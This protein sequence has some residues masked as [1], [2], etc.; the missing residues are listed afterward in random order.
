MAKGLLLKLEQS[1]SI[2]AFRK[3]KWTIRRIAGELFESKG[4]VW[5]FLR[6][7]ETY[8]SSKRP[9][10]C[11]KLDS[12][13]KRLVL[14]GASNGKSSS[15]RIKFDLNLNV[16]TRTLRRILSKS[17]HFKYKKRKAV[18]RLTPPHRVTRVEWAKSHVDLGIGWD[19]IVFSDEKK[20]NLDGP[21]GL[22]YYWHDLRKEE[23]TFLSRQNGGGSVM[24]WAGFSSKGRTEIAFLQGHQDSYAYCDTVANYLLP[25]AHMHHGG[26]FVF[27]QDNASIHASHDTMAFLAEHNIPLLSWPSLC[28]DLNPIENFWG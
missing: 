27:Q 1:G 17:P 16:S 26:E 7:P 15:S 25:I 10:R 20:F 3:A 12:R 8:G 19:Q 4:A 9:G 18:P 22:Q 6:S 28:P 14:R 13:D 2:L 5:N 11:S 24:I 23:H 21:D